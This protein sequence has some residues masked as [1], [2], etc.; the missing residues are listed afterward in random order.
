MASL[1]ETLKSNFSG[2]SNSP[3]NKPIKKTLCLQF[4]GLVFFITMVSGQED[5]KK[6]PLDAKMKLG[7]HLCLDLEE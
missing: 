7:F 3:S 4:Q 6:V 2:N 5:I 1:E